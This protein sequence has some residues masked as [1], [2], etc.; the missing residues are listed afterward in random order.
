MSSFAATLELE[1]K[2]FQVVSF[3][4]SVHRHTDYQGRAASRLLDSI[5]E[6][7]IV[8]PA[9]DVT[10]YKWLCN[11]ESKDGKVKFSQIDQSSTFN[12]VEFK[13][14]LCFQY[15][16]SFHDNTAHPMVIHIK[17]STGVLSITSGSTFQ[18]N[19]FIQATQ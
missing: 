1:G 4:Y 2:T 13:Q 11:N 15:S 10:F 19:Q 3:E 18:E 12:Q 8:T 17:I 16:H 14:S 5:I 9:N 6:M 7:E